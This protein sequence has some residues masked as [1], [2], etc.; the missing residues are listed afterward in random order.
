MVDSLD[1]GFVWINPLDIMALTRLEYG[2]DLFLEDSIVI[3]IVTV[4]STKIIKSMV[5]LGQVQDR[6]PQE[7]DFPWERSA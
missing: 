7:M 2:G 4:M 5:F 3:T 6:R 1:E